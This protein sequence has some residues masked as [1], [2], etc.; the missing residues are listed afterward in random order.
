MQQRLDRSKAG[1]AAA[2][3]Y[4]HTPEG[5]TQL[6]DTVQALAAYEVIAKEG[7]ATKLPNDPL[8]ELG[9]ATRRFLAPVRQRPTNSAPRCRNWWSAEAPAPRI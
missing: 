1:L 8:P 9:S 3:A 7:C 2:G 6:A 5:K 4:F